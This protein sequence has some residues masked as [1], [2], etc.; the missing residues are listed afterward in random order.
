MKRLIAVCVAFSTLAHPLWAK[1]PALDW[2]S[3]A[4][5]SFA[6]YQKSGSDAFILS[7]EEQLQQKLTKND[8]SYLRSKLGQAY[9]N[10]R[11]QKLELKQSQDRL[12][13]AWEKNA[14]TVLSLENEKEL[15]VKLDGKLLDLA[16]SDSIEDVSKKVWALLAP[17]HGWGSYPDDKKTSS[18]FLD[19]SFVASGSCR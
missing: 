4:I 13:I 18:F 8:A 3:A 5:R 12:V 6:K 10:S 7:L 15:Q 9:K 1:D 14:Q 11:A 16:P 2:Q 17:Q 19:Q